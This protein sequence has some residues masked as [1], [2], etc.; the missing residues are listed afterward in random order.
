V[1]KLSE[2][3]RFLG[4]QTADEASAELRKLVLRLDDTYDQLNYMVKLLGGSPDEDAE[5]AVRI[6]RTSVNEAID[7]LDTAIRQLRTDGPDAA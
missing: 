7:F 2:W 1:A 3:Y 4:V 5:Q 6:A